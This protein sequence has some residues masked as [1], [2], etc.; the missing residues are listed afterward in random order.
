MGAERRFLAGTYQFVSSPPPL[1]TS[2][3]LFPSLS[4]AVLSCGLSYVKA[5]VRFVHKATV[6]RVSLDPAFLL[7]SSTIFHPQ[8]GGQP[9]DTGTVVLPG[10][11][12]AAGV[13]SVSACRL[14][15]DLDDIVHQGAFANPGT[16]EADG[17]VA[18]AEVELRVCESTRR[19]HARLHS[20]GH[21]LDAAMHNC[22]FDFPATK[23][24]H[25]PDA[26]SVEY[27][28]NI[29]PEKREAA[30]QALEAEC[31]R[32]VERAT[33]VEVMAE[34]DGDRAKPLCGALGA[35]IGS[36]E[37]LRLVR[38]TSDFDWCPCGGTHVENT[39]EIGKVVVTK[40]GFKK[41]S[42]KISYSLQ[43]G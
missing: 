23:G 2:H 35:G 10:R 43:S 33:A 32:L 37:S 12:G 9:S 6:V 38:V 16:A 28:G 15:R 27:T 4:A 36:E 25:F 18:G 14:D 22:G 5:C 13:F 31:N 19:L 34:V 8:G 30:R 21:L 17:W 41:G 24:Y 1:L 7:L 42:L 11:D 20:A 3:S 26:P 39:M 29:E 40:V